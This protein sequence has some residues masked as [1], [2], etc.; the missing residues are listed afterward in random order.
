MDYL[1]GTIDTHVHSAPDVRK[2]KMTDMELMHA[3]VKRGVRAIVIKSHHMPTVARA[4]DVNEIC[5]A[6]Y[7]DSTDFQMFGGVTLN[8]YVG[9]LNPWAVD[10]SLSMGGKVVWLPT[11]HSEQQTKRE[12][13][14]GAVI[15]VK[16]GKVAPELETIFSL[17]TD[18]GAALATSH[19]SPDNIF[20]VVEAARRAGV[21]RIIISHPESNLV[22][23]TLEEQKRLVTDYDVMLERCYAQPVGGGKYISNLQDNYHAYEEI[24]SRNIILATDAG[25]TQNPYW[26]ESFEESICFMAKHGATE[27]DLDRMTRKNAAQMLNI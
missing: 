18:Y 20:V 12:H 6:T 2:R 21:R 11:V 13:T 25:Q 22:G 9:G 23:L 5:K 17:I 4:A 19:L 27:E 24:G 3:A 1:K 8:S 15:C 26:Y 10:S 16:D 7:G 14:K